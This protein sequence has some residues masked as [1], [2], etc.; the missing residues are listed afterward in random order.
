MLLKKAAI[1]S[2]VLP[3]ESVRANRHLKL[4]EVVLHF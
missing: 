3:E 4:L 2:D 1:E